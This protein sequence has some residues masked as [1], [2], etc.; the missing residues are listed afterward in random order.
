MSCPHTHTTA[1]LAAFGEAPVE[2]E[3]HLAQCSECRTAV[4]EHSETLAILEP[5]APT[6]TEYSRR[7][8][9]PAVGFLLA[10]AALLA[11]QFSLPQTSTVS[12]VISDKVIESTP[13]D[14]S[15]FNDPLDD[16]LAS[17]EIELALYYLEES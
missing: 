7:W 6:A 9:P 2:F 15:L 17:L 14:Q 16:D 3:E 13:N 5:L 10:A 4:H 12:H 11:V 8:K 1:V